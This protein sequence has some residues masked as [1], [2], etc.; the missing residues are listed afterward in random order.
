MENRFG[1]DNAVY[2]NSEGK[3]LREDIT[4][5]PSVRAERES[6]A[7]V[8]GRNIRRIRES[9]KR[10]Q[11]TLA[12]E[13][14]VSVKMLS[15]YEN[16]KRDMPIPILF[17]IADVL[18]VSVDELVPARLKK[19]K[20]TSPEEDALIAVFR[21][22]NTYDKSA[23]IK[24]SEALLAFDNAIFANSKGETLR[25]HIAHCLS[26]YD[27]FRQS[28]P[29]LLTER[30]WDILYY[31]VKYREV[32][33]IDRGYQKMV[34]GRMGLGDRKS[35]KPK[36]RFEQ[37]SVALLD[38]DFFE[39]LGWSWVDIQTLFLM[40]RNR[41]PE[42]K[43]TNTLEY[44]K[45]LKNDLTQR[46]QELEMKTVDGLRNYADMQVIT[47]RN[48]PS[49][50]DQFRYMML[51]GLLDLIYGCAN[52]NQNIADLFKHPVNPQDVKEPISSVQQYLA[53]HQGENLIVCSEDKAERTKAALSWMG[54]RKGFY[55]V[56]YRSN[57]NTMKNRI[58]AFTGIKSTDVTCLE[59]P[60]YEYYNLNSE[61][62][63]EMLDTLAKP[64][65]LC[66]AKQILSFV[67]KITQG[68]LNTALLANSCLI[69]DDVQL[70]QPQELAAMI[71]GLKII[72]QYGGRC[73]ILA[74]A[75]PKILEWIL[76]QENIPMTIAPQFHHPEVSNR[77]RLKLIGDC[78]SVFNSFPFSDILR[79]GEKRR[80]LLLCNTT[81]NASW[82]FRKLKDR[83]VPVWKNATD[84]TS[85]GIC[86][87]TGTIES[88]QDFD[89]LYTSMCTVFDLIQ[90]M[91]CVY[92][93][94]KYDLGDE[95]NVYVIRNSD[96]VS[97][98][99]F[100]IM[101][102]Q[103]Y[104]STVS[105]FERHD[106]ALLNEDVKAKIVDEIYDLKQNPAL[107]SHGYYAQIADNLRLF[108]DMSL[109]LYTPDVA[110]VNFLPIP[111]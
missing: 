20:K 46:C 85:N 100:A 29:A 34:R 84:L 45:Y 14:K 91:E 67:Y 2:A 16:G 24:S 111:K 36:F 96:G 109:C 76:K 66:T 21:K 106:G 1:L 56:P 90:R 31:A 70:Y 39:N 55:M 23:I 94:R 47:A 87:A 12:F 25:D 28:N 30:E 41:Y 8:L 86:V 19:Q 9:Q 105:A 22:L 101:P 103:L 33:K 73:L 108:K 110:E 104:K 38:Q 68:E 69:L 32:G 60:L 54:N 88:N 80:V 35:Q 44:H 79:Q 3:T 97:D 10:T 18:M 50:S 11:E 62:R 52:A 13:A 65:T 82:V 93:S 75:L 27:T 40:I 59:H 58:T 48:L 17:K 83:G 6:D 95:P 37:L 49:E 57:L 5:C 43:T 4:H 53:D 92:R 98:E 102:E 26:V 77:H 71:Y 42:A 15:E 89:V 63:G 7:V 74:S 61:Q 81:E 64:L 99:L 107:F 72:T 78:N 51:K